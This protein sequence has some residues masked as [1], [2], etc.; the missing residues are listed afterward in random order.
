VHPQP[1]AVDAR[2]TAVVRLKRALTLGHCSALPIS[3]Y[4]C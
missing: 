4:G 3:T 1:K 2:T